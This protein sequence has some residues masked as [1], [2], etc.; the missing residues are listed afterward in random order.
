MLWWDGNVVSRL[1][2]FKAATMSN[3][4]WVE[5]P[6]GPLAGPG[7]RGCFPGRFRASAKLKPGLPIPDAPGPQSEISPESSWGVTPDSRTRRRERKR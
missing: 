3:F 5:K 6:N 4:N 1:H 7:P 2:P